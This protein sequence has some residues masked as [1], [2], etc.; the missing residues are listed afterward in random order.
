MKPL[1]VIQSR[2]QQLY[3]LQL[4]HQVSDFLVTDPELAKYLSNRELGTDEA[5]LIKQSSDGLDL[6]LF[7]DHE[8]IRRLTSRAE[9]D[10]W[11]AQDLNDWWQALE[12]VSHF[13]CV[14]WRAE[15]DRST[16]A[17]E[18]ELQA[19]IDKFLLTA[20][21]LGDQHGQPSIDTLQHYLF[22]RF[23]L[24]P[25]LSQALKQR[26]HRANE[27]A[28]RYCQHL[29][30]RHRVWPLEPRLLNELRRFY[31]FDGMAKEAHIN[32]MS[33]AYLLG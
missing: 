32:R 24:R 12:G 27:L 18:L 28:A 26:Y 13:L 23:R 22:K 15:R 20:L 14:V 2:L 4:S 6:S 1:E 16:T 17:M 7:I 9:T 8:L 3:D 30:R 21:M 31:R 29:Q 10:H 5:L 33:G 25:G 19:E 11:T